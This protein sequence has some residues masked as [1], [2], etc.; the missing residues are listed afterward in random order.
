MSKSYSIVLIE[1][2]KIEKNLFKGKMLLCV[3]SQAQLVIGGFR[4]CLQ[5]WQIGESE[6]LGRMEEHHSCG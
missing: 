4:L 3:E 1:K 2:S 6:N 5:R